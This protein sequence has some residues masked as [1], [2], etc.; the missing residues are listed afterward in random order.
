[1]LFAYCSSL[2]Y[3]YST[4]ALHTTEYDGDCNDIID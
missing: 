1:M 3:Y 4:M 2:F